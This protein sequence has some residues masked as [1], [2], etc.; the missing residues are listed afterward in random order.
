[1]AVHLEWHSLISFASCLLISPPA[2][3]LAVHSSKSKPREANVL[4]RA[5]HE[6]WPHLW[7]TAVLTG[8]I[9]HVQDGA[10]PDATES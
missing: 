10:V 3:A 9:G 1:M 6:V 5:V 4:H 8:I 2:E 7:S